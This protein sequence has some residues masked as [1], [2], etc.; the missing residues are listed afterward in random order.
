MSEYDF[1]TL[2]SKYPDLIARM[3]ATF[4]AHKFILHLA[5]ENQA[6]YVA[7]LYH[8]RNNLHR[9][10]PTPFRIVHGVLARH[11]H[12]YPNL[13]QKVREGVSSPDIFGNAHTC[14]EWRKL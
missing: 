10:R 14:S 2:Y 5:E 6:L 7:A 4:T 13:V 3:P 1:S 9:G 8:Y 12:N 11:L